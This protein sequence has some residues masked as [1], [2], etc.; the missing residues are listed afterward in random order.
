MHRTQRSRSSQNVSDSIG[1]GGE[2]RKK[3]RESEA[4]VFEKG[5]ALPDIKGAGG[6]GRH[7]PLSNFIGTARVTVPAIMG[8]FSMP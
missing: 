2:A 1:R 6:L 4:N 5:F 8:I 7:V 3:I